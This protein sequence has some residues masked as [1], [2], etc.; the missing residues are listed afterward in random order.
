MQ[1]P[2]YSYAGIDLRLRAEKRNSKQRAK[3]GGMSVSLIKGTVIPRPH[4]PRPLAVVAR[5]SIAGTLWAAITIGFSTPIPALAADAAR[6]TKSSPSRRCQAE[7]GWLVCSRSEGLNQ[8]RNDEERD[9]RGRDQASHHHDGRLPH[10][11]I[12]PGCHVGLDYVVG[13]RTGEEALVIAMSEPVRRSPRN[14]GPRQT[15]YVPTG[16]LALIDLLG[17]CFLGVQSVCVDVCCPHQ[18]GTEQP[19]REG[20]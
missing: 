4:L 15:A 16:A 17:F 10:D 7:V 11:G 20:H 12:F 14:A 13:E 8:R 18:L 9:E 2:L 6:V 1:H 19:R 5:A 3:R